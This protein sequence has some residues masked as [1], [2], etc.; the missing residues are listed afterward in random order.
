VHLGK[1][2]FVGVGGIGVA[3]GLGFRLLRLMGVRPVLGSAP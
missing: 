3:Q 1:A 2:G